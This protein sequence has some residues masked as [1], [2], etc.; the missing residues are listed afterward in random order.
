M[1]I[2]PCDR[3]RLFNLAM[4]ALFSTHSLA[5]VV[6]S[7]T[8][9][10]YPSDSKEVSVA[11]NNVGTSPVLLQSWLDNGDVNAKPEM[12]KVPFILTPPINRVEPS[13]SQ[14][15]RIRYT[16]GVLPMDKESVFWLNVL[17]LPAKKQ[18][19]NG[20]SVMQMTFRSRIK[21]F[22]RPAG[23][24]GNA[25]D[26]AKAVIWQAQGNGIQATNP[27]PYY[28][29]FVTIKVNGKQIAGEMVAPRSSLLFNLPGKAG[30]TLTGDFVNDY[31][32]VNQFE[33]VIR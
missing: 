24:K 30:S 15:L 9:V 2:L 22:Y 7:N 23:L 31:G 8:R 1:R 12:I 26:T 20:D 21:L 4:F 25:N 29:S 11:I 10:I 14:T 32:A 19:K 16:D 28:V 3:Y 5:S 27:T 6:I 17:E 33:G 13:K 18:A